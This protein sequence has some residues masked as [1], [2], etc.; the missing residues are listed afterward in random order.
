MSPTPTRF[1]KQRTICKWLLVSLALVVAIWL[2]ILLVSR[3]SARAVTSDEALIYLVTLPLFIVSALYFWRRHALRKTGTSVS[4][5][6]EVD[7]NSGSA[8]SGKPAVKLAPLAILGA[9]S[10]TS[11]GAD[12]AQFIEAVSNRQVRPVPD[13]HL[14]DDDG[15]PALSSRARNLDLTAAERELARAIA[16]GALENAP[17][18]HE[19]RD[20]VLRTAALLDSVVE[21]TMLDWPLSG[22][23]NSASL[24]DA[25]VPM[26][27]GTSR[28][29]E[30]AHIAH[31]QVK[32]LVSTR[33][34]PLERQF[35]QTSVT[36]RLTS[37]FP[38]R[39]QFTLQ[40]L[41][42]SDDI[43]ALSLVR[44]FA[45]SVTH[46]DTPQVMLLL[47][48]ESTLCPSIVEDW[49]SHGLLFDPRRPNGL[50][51]GEGAFAILF[52][53]EKSRQN[54]TREPLGLLAH[55]SNARR[56]ISADTAGRAS[57]ACLVDTIDAALKGSGLSTDAIGT[58]VCDA[59][60]RANRTLECIGAMMKQTPQLDAI[61]DRFAINEACGHLGAASVVGL[62]AAG[63]LQAETAAHPVLVFSVGHS[64]DRAAAIILPATARTTAASPSRPQAA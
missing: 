51:M 4:Q 35:L 30:A 37:L 38:A 32:L 16:D 60:H 44:E 56:E 46:D 62:L 43:T 8:A 25:A 9:W 33:L 49:A 1:S 59:D 3:I 41:A 53:N 24:S 22:D 6:D 34:K 5:A 40:L 55:V 48:G 13:D 14:I 58:V 7:I 45:E 26:L 27:R 15:F 17:D 47:A 11:V 29:S 28:M 39:H 57:H 61:Q 63:A 52:A 64:L 31:V 12:S 20:A 18:L 19:W 50:M 54:A 21:Q 23:V 2:L 36:N 10:S 42:V